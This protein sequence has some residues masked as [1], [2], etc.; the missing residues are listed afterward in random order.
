[1]RLY[2][3]VAGLYLSPLQRGLQTAHAISR[4]SVKYKNN[5]PQDSMYCSWAANHETIIILDAGNH[6]GV[7]DAF[8]AL[9]VFAQALHLPNSIFFEDEDS[10]NGMATACAVVVPARYYEAEFVKG[11]DPESF[12][13]PDDEI[14]ADANYDYAGGN[15]E[16]EF[17]KFLKSYRLAQS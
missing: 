15:F 12:K 6:R 5:S 8:D 10:M 16:F 3:F 4:M 1:M 9:G 14:I 7:L 17:I 13:L 11:S 2:A